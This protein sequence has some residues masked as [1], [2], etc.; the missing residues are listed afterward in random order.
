MV[1]SVRWRWKASARMMFCPARRRPGRIAA[2]MRLMSFGEE[3][4][5]ST[6]DS[7]LIAIRRRE[8]SG[9]TTT[10]FLKPSAMEAPLVASSCVRWNV[11]DFA[12]VSPSRRTVSK[13]RT[14]RSFRT[15]LRAAGA[16]CL[17][18]AVPV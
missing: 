14:G 2:V 1:Q 5:V 11:Q 6:T 9:M 16:G 8:P 12:S 15:P 3:I 17:A 4:G 13:G 18:G 10:A 7:P